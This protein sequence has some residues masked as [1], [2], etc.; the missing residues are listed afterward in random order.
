MF[1]D[2]ALPQLLS[3]SGYTFNPWPA[4]TESSEGFGKALAVEMES[5]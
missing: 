4:S 1:L 5:K 3:A 2:S